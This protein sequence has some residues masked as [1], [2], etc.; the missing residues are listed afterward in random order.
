[1]AAIRA[2][3]STLQ[4]FSNVEKIN[5]FNMQAVEMIWYLKWV[6]SLHLLVRILGW[7]NKK[8]TDFDESH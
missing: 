5:L 4:H 3:Y 2:E 7:P 1:M 6:C 8:L